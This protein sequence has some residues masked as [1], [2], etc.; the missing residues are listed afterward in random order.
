MAPIYIHDE[1]N[2]ARSVHVFRGCIYVFY[3]PCGRHLVVFIFLTTLDIFINWQRKRFGPIRWKGIKKN[4]LRFLTSRLYPN[5]S[6][7]TKHDP[8]DGWCVGWFALLWRFDMRSRAYPKWVLKIIILARKAGIV[9]R[10]KSTC[11]YGDLLRIGV[12]LGHVMQQRLA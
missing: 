2:I 6:W 3:L 11:G 1:T 10:G 4:Q 8:N 7:Y 9:N 5:G 12:Q